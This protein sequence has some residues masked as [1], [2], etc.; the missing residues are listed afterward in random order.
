MTLSSDLP[1]EKPDEDVFGLDPFAGAIAKSGGARSEAM[2]KRLC[3]AAVSGKLYDISS[4][5][6]ER[7]KAEFERSP[8]KRTTVL[9]LMDAVEKRL[10]RMIAENPTRTNFQARYEEMVADYNEEKDRVT[11]EATFQA[12]IRFV[13]ELSTEESRAMREGLDPAALTLFDLLKKPD[14]QKAEIERLKGVAASLLTT[15]EQRRLEIQDWR[16]KEATRD[17][18]RQE[19]YDFLYNDETG[20]PESYSPEEIQQKSAIVFAHVFSARSGEPSYL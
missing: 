16:A 6:F 9:N 3:D 13:A 18:I 19:I 8:A 1:I 12:L 5:D 7:L 4:I 11:I 2:Q 17:A 20:L 10:A 15:L 14:L